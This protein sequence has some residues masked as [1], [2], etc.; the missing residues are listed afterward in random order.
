MERSRHIESTRCGTTVCCWAA[1]K[2]GSHFHGRVLSDSARRSRGVGHHH[3]GADQSAMEPCPAPRRRFEKAMHTGHSSPESVQGTRRADRT[4]RRRTSRTSFPVVISCI[5]EKGWTV[6]GL[7]PG[8]YTSAAS[9]KHT[10][11]HCANSPSLGGV[12]WKQ[13]HLI[14]FSKVG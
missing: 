4:A 5:S 1:Q 7:N 6:R 10:R 12:A 13:K 2:H 8:P 3:D 14:R 11:Y 9:A